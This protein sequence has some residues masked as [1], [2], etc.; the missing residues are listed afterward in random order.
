MFIDV[1]KVKIKAGKGGDG[2]VSFYR[3][4]YVANGGPDG[5]DGGKGGDVIFKVDDNMST[6]VDFRYRRKYIADNGENGGKK[7]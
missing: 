4:K 5:G 7:N 1:V 3:E 2:I 6:L